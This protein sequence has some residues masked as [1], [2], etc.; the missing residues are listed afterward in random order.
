MS[1]AL[2]V[3]IDETPV[4]RLWL[5]ERKHFCF[6]YDSGWLQNSRIPLSLSLPLRPEPY[7]DDESHAFFANLLPEEK[8][9]I[10]IA[11]N[12]G[13][14]LQNDYGLLERIGGDCAGA[15]SLYPESGESKQDPAEYRQL[16]L[17]ELNA[18]IAELPQRPLLAGEKG[19]RLSLAGAQKKLPVFYDD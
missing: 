1:A 17:D 16:S 11:R 19:V 15:V 4:G 7:L 18:V 2:L 5:D 13:I 14:S 9:R 8:I 6:Q 3:R 10:I 12:L